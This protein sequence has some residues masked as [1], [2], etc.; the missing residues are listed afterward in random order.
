M[1]VGINLVVIM[2]ETTMAKNETVKIETA[3]GANLA[4]R[5]DY[6]AGAHRG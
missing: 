2:K 3:S 6:A 4:G 5:L 1:V